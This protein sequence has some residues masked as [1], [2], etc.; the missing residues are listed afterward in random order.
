MWPPT[1]YQGL[2][3]PLPLISENGQL[4]LIVPAT[5][6]LILSSVTCQMGVWG[7][8]ADDRRSSSATSR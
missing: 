2:L 4:N 7:I 1:A 5:L 8:M 3:Y 6:I